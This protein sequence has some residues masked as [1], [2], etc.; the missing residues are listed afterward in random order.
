MEKELLDKVAELVPVLNKAGGKELIFFLSVHKVGY[1]RDIEKSVSCTIYSLS[2][3]AR[4]LVKQGI[5]TDI[6]DK[7]R[8][9]DE[10]AE[11]A[12]RDI[13]KLRGA[14]PYN[15]IDF[16]KLN[17]DIDGV[18]AEWLLS[19]VEVNLS[20]KTKE[21]IQNYDVLRDKKPQ[22]KQR[23]DDISKTKQEKS[24]MEEY[25]KGND[26]INK[27]VSS[28]SEEDVKDKTLEDAIDCVMIRWAL[29]LENLKRTYPEIYKSAVEPRLETIEKSIE[30]KINVRIELVQKN[31]NQRLLAKI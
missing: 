29:C 16:I 15:S 26:W 17:P 21:R 28:I 12:Y 31:I 30:P 5:L 4:S 24:N 13:R 20:D 7:D 19:W 9:N 22:E 25:Y 14:T 6:E 18:L 1:I 3:A 23:R 2:T 10:D 11:N 27:F 8:R